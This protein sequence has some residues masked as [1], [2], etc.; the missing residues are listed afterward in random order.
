[1]KIFK[2]TVFQLPKDLQQKD[3]AEIVDY[4]NAN[5]ASGNENIGIDTLELGNPLRKDSLKRLMLFLHSDK[6]PQGLPES[7]RR[8]RTELMKKLL[9]LTTNEIQIERDINFEPNSRFVRIASTVLEQLVVNA[10]LDFLF[11]Y[12]L[13][14]DRNLSIA[15][16]IGI[17]ISLSLAVALIH[18]AFTVL[19][20]NKLSNE[21]YDHSH[22]AM[23]KLHPEKPEEAQLRYTF[24][25]LG[26]AMGRHATLT[27]LIFPIICELSFVATIFL[28]RESGKLDKGFCDK[29]LTVFGTSTV[30]LLLCNSWSFVKTIKAQKKNEESEK[31]VVSLIEDPEQRPS[32]IARMRDELDLGLFP[33]ELTFAL[34]MNKI[35]LSFAECSLLNAFVAQARI[36]RI[37]QEIKKR[38]KILPN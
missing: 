38:P 26:R 35:L 12:V 2:D 36:D 5:K 14:K 1:M 16:C 15:K 34:H 6:H 19:A 28:L 21:K 10:A 8:R 22:P 27:R 7:E 9:A 29:L 30:I 37:F 18:G 13:F 11:A 33:E 4:Y 17:Y 24:F 3:L 20:L 23:K 25:V 31:E 32:F